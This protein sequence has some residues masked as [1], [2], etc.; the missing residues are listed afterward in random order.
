MTNGNET[1]YQAVKN[2]A[3]A[4]PDRTALHYM[5][6]DISYKRLFADINALAA[7]FK[8]QNIKRGDAVTLCMPNLPQ[9]VACF[10]ALNKIG[11]VAHMVHPLAPVAQ[12]ISYMQKVDSKM[13]VIPDIFAVQHA[14]I[15]ES[16]TPVLLC[17]PAYYLG[18][19]KHIAF[20]I[21]NARSVAYGR[22]CPCVSFYMDAVKSL[23]DGEEE[24]DG[25]RTAVYLHS[26]GTGGAP[27]TICLSSRA[28]NSL[29]AC[30]T[31][32]LSEPDFKGGSML[33]V[34]PMFHG[35]GLAMGVH[36]FL[37]MGGTVTLMLKFRTEETLKLIAKNKVNYLI[38][39]PVL[40]EALLKR[41]EFSGKKLKNLRVAFVGGDFVSDKLIEKFNARMREN[42][43]AARLFEGYGLTETVTVCAANTR[44]N[45]RDGSVGKPNSCLKIACFDGDR[46]LAPNEQ[47]ELCISGPQLM[48]GYLNDEEGTNEAFFVAD[49]ER[50]VRSGD[51]GYIDE[52]GFVFFKSRLKRI[53]KVSGVTVFPSEIENL[54]MNFFLEIG[55]AHAIAA[56]DEMTG[57]AIV[58]FVCLSAP[59]A[60]ED[61]ADLKIRIA[62]LVE[63]RL[64]VFARPKNIFFL[65]ELPKTLIGKVDTNKLKEIYL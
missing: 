27:K 55:E 64:S 47:G 31:E 6:V 19:L 61:A 62:E 5:G 35:F 29:C 42:G 49:G 45:N 28:I 34:L 10:Y 56:P 54:C 51:I 16:E 15:M 23:P 3:M 4:H 63:S 50:W 57:S 2:T 22:K 59:L 17:S 7:W 48:N 65:P 25:E 38:G 39:V 60:E 52:D 12:L 1:L 18:K 20:S 26:G 44:D 9:C 46:R 43:S 14:E 30:S 40:Y 13:L 24:S 33:A 58:M 53:A 8:S 36:A 32:L 21:K 41:K 11:A 37:T